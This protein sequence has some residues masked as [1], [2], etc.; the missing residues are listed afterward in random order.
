MFHGGIPE[1]PKG[2]DCKS[3]VS[4]FGG[5]NPPSPTNEKSFDSA[6]SELFSCFFDFWVL[7]K[8]WPG[9]GRGKRDA[10]KL[11]GLADIFSVGFARRRWA[12]TRFDPLLTHTGNPS[13]KGRKR[14]GGKSDGKC[15][16]GVGWADGGGYGWI[17]GWGIAGAASGII[18]PEGP[19]ILDYC[20][21]EF[22]IPKGFSNISSLPHPIQRFLPVPNIRF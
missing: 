11:P 16:D 2:A 18:L 19:A 1:W 6:E 17:L 12:K 3:V 22:D 10:D 7:R 4:D 15:V 13:G 5:S 20:G 14:S 21:A 8:M 9:E